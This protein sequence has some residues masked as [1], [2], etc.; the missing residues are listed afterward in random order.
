MGLAGLLD[1]RTMLPLLGMT[2]SE[3]LCLKKSIDPVRQPAN[4]PKDKKKEAPWWLLTGVIFSTINLPMSFT[5][6]I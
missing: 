5:P 3:H 6:I 2:R 4:C 1:L